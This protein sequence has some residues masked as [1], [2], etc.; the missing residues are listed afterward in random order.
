MLKSAPASDPVPAP[1][2]PESREEPETVTAPPAPDD[3]PVLEIRRLSKSFG[4]KKILNDISLSVHRGEI[5]GFL[6]PNGSGK[7]TTIKLMLGLL[8][9]DE[10][11]IFI[12]G[13]NVHTQHDAAL[14]QVGGIIENPEMYK[15]LTGR[16]NLEQYCRMYG[17]IPRERI[18]R[19][20]RLVGL[21]DR[22]DDKLAKYSLGMRQRLGLAQALLNHPSLLVLDEPTN[23]LD[24][25]GIH[26]LRDT[27]TG[28]A[29]Q[30]VSVFV[31]SHQLSELEQ[32][33]THV[34][35]L[36]RGTLL[37][38]YTMDELHR[39]GQGGSV[40][41][42]LRVENGAAIQ[43]VM[44]RLGLDFSVTADGGYSLMLPETRVS[45]LLREVAVHAGLLAAVPMQ[46]SLEQAFLEIVGSYDSAMGASHGQIQGV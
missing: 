28:L 32:M 7:T 6:G 24:P 31:S 29:A 41:L 45:E 14:R 22:T 27:L 44:A 9:I 1:V 5:F 19:V 38:V 21:S 3:T 30:G 8:S 23:G 2:A 12:C 15:Y 18:D 13:H 10:G 42:T 11:E 35:V 17:G 39:A 40:T 37:G 36:D 4:S 20:V 46:R 33:C 25:A 16:Q 26:D 34:G 43:A